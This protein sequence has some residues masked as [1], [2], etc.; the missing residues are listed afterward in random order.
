M[1]AI[2]KAAGTSVALSTFFLVVYGSCNLIT[3]LRPHVGSC[4]FD[5]ERHIPFVPALIIP[6]MSIDLFFIAAPFLA[7][8]DRERRTLALRIVSAI[9]IAAVCFLLFPLRFGFERPAFDGP[10]G[11]IFSGFHALD[12]PFNECPSLHIALL[13]ILAEIYLRHSK[14]PV[15]VFLAVWFLLIAFSP[16]PTYQHHVVDVLG[17]G[18][19]AVVCLHLFRDE[20]LRQPF[21]PNRRVGLCYA[22][23][24]VV[25][26]ALGFGWTPWSY[27]L[28]W[29]AGSL[30]LVA[31]GYLFFGPG[32]FRKEGGRLPWTSVLL[33]GPM[34][35]GHRL[36]LW[37]YARRCRDYDRVTDH[38]WIGRRLSSA[39]ARRARAEGVGAVVDLTAESSEKG[40]FRA[41]SYRQFPT[42][43]LTAP[44]PGQIDEA[45]AFIRQ[46]A[47]VGIVYLHCKIGY[48]RTAV[49]AGAYLLAE[50]QA[51]SVEQALE[52]LRRARPSLIA[53]PEAVTALHAFRARMNGTREQDG[54]IVCG[55]E[56]RRSRA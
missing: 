23:G 1:K 16:V 12:L 56:T 8:S 48:S 11:A 42:L 52:T 33:L 36:S 41:L 29:P 39:E 43:D 26:A 18:V 2:W 22:A 20:P 31:S 32:I 40:P 46:H 3:S 28:L 35:V 4:F 44:T 53:R 21:L 49:V 51:G 15:R 10:L 25:C 14:G 5:W 27:V 37:Y 50:G 7:R 9:S 55:S 54:G 17:G 30:A 19:L 13:A 34:L 45:V 6:Y 24:A 38:F 47:K